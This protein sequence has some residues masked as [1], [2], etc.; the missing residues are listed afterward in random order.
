MFRVKV[1]IARHSVV[2]SPS[3]A[4]YRE[5]CARPLAYLQTL[6][7]VART[8]DRTRRRESADQLGDTPPIVLYVVPR[9]RGQGHTRAFDGML[10]GTVL[11]GW[12][13]PLPIVLLF[14]P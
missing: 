11:I 4:P 1:I 7:S 6:L 5:P 10:V 2:Q 8:A 9:M 12:I 3:E 13:G 14:C